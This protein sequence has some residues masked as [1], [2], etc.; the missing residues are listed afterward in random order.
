M[1]RTINIFSI[2]LLGIACFSCSKIDNYDGPDASLQG[3]LIDA[4]T[5]EPFIT[6]TGSVQLKLEEISWSDTPTPQYIPSKYGGTYEDTQLFSGHYVVTPTDGPFW[7]YEEGVEV[8][9]DGKTNQD[10]ELT[11]YLKITNF[12][13]SLEGTTLTMNFNLE[14][15]IVADLPQIIDV[16]PFVNLTNFVGSGATINE[17]SDPN[18]IEINSNWSEE[19]AG[20]TYELTVTDLKPGRTFYAR[21]GVRVND[22][23]KKYNYSEI[24]EVQVP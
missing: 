14:A 6:E 4:T 8:D 7:P 15:P 10:F 16:K 11:P 3:N 24:I 9:I 20:T 21:V 22:S 12:T 18:R 2:L 19:I 13:H 5:G 1:K 17:Y 23:F